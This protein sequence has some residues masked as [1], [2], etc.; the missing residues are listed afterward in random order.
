MSNLKKIETW[1]L[2]QLAGG[3]KK[4]MAEMLGVS[5]NTVYALLKGELKD[6]FVIENE[7]GTYELIKTY[8]KTAISNHTTKKG[9]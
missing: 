7:S 9:N 5:R 6:S 1:K 8:T 3:D 2:L 4:K